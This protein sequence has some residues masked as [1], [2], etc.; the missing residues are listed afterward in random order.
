MPAA[1]NNQQTNKMQTYNHKQT[2]AVPV[3]SSA[4]LDL[5]AVA[6]NVGIPIAA[7]FA[8]NG[9]KGA[10]NIVIVM[11]ILTLCLMPLAIFCILK[12]G[13]PTPRWREW[14]SHIS[15]A[16]IV[17]LLVWNGWIFCSVCFALGWFATL[18]LFMVKRAAKRSNMW[19]RRSG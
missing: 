3:G 15:D 11:A 5:A 1:L 4:V 12:P 6:F 9:S 17:S 10:G 14:L 2:G 16:I 19:L 13:E 18:M 8:V 7:W